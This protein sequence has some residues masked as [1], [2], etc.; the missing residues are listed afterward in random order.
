M[1]IY[2]YIYLYCACSCL[3]VIAFTEVSQITEGFPYH[4]T[5]GPLKVPITMAWVASI[6][7]TPYYLFIYLFVYLFVCLFV[8][9]FI[10]WGGGGIQD[11]HDAAMESATL[12]NS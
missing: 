9:L 4:Y 6:F 10:Y 8:Y 5:S 3:V 2:I 11:G 1:Y 7:L 12:L